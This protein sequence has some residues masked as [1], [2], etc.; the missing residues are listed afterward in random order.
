MEEGGGEGGRDERGGG[1]GG[2]RRRGGRKRGEGTREKGKLNNYVI[3]QLFYI[4]MQAQVMTP[5]NHKPRLNFL[6][7]QSCSYVPQENPLLDKAILSILSLEHKPRDYKQ[8]AN[9]I[10]WPYVEDGFS[11]GLSLQ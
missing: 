3:F 11:K 10:S 6:S 7:V 9:L 5:L 1:R 2:K 4:T 8:P